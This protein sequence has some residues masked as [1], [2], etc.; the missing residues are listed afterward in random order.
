M[1]ILAAGVGSRLGKSEP[2]CFS[3]LPDGQTILARQINLARRNGVRSLIIVCGF[4]KSLL[5]EKH[6][7]VL[8]CYNPSFHVTNTSKSLWRALNMCSGDVIWTNGDIV[9]H[10]EVLKNL[11]AA[12]GNVV[13]VDEKDCGDEEIKYCTS[14]QG[15]IAEI[16]KNVR[17][18]R[19]E[20]LGL[21]RISA[22][23]LPTLVDCLSNCADDDYFEK[24][25]ELSIE[26]DV[27]WKPLGV[28]ELPVIE[29]DFDAD[30]EKVKKIFSLTPNPTKSPG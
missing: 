25:I 24:A 19:G 23:D 3:V 27:I 20:A 4:K 5:M 29:V 14:P 1:V 26:K 13:V 9:F 18:S 21:N 30:W 7:D 17:A 16:S 22:A 11:I 12:G 28:G 10:E 6:P 8:Y 2:K 15:H